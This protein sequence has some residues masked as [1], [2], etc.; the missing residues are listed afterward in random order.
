MY[1]CVC[2]FLCVSVF[3]C[4]LAFVCAFFALCPAGFY[5]LCSLV[6]VGIQRF[7]PERFPALERLRSRVRFLLTYQVELRGRAVAVADALIM[8]FIVVSAVQVRTDSDTIIL[9]A[10]KDE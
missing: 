7:K 5:K 8:L 9:Q 4:Y 10:P 1:A 3:P 6:N 2:A